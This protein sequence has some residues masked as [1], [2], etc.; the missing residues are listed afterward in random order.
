MLKLNNE[1]VARFVVPSVEGCV[2]LGAPD[3]LIQHAG[4]IIAGAKQAIG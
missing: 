1:A 3:A 2:R 4:P